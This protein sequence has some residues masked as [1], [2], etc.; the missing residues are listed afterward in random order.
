MLHENNMITIEQATLA[1]CPVLALM[2]RQLIDDGGDDSTMTD[3][4]LESRMYHWLQEDPYYTGF[5]FKL[6]GETIG[7]ALIDVSERWLRHFFICRKYRRRGYGREAVRLL[8]KHLGIEEIGL[9]CLT[10]N[11]I[12]QAFWRSFQHE[13]YS[14]NFSVQRPHIARLRDEPE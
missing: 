13:A 4:Q 7:Y 11:V 6:N 5:V 14:T 3:P 2:N 10:K 8:M 1:D 12:G 9:S